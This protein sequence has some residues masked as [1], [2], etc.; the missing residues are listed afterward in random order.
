MQF[1]LAGASADCLQPVILFICPPETQK[2]VRK[3]VRKQNW[4][5]EAECGYKNMI[6]DGTF[7]RVLLDGQG[8]LDGGLFIRADMDDV[9]TLCGKMGRLEG[10][11]N[12]PGNGSRFTIGGV[13]IVNDILCC[14]TT[15]HVLVNGPDTSETASSDDEDEID[16]EERQEY[17]VGDALPP[18]LPSKSS[19]Q[20]D[21]KGDEAGSAHSN[22]SQET[23]IGRLLT[24]SNWKRGTLTSNEDWSL[25]RLDAVSSSDKWL[26]NRFDHPGPEGQDT[27]TVTINELVRTDDEITEAEVIILAGCTGLQKG[28]L[29]TTA[30][31]LYLDNATFEAREIVTHEPLSKFPTT[32]SIYWNG[33]R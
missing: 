4:L 23:R 17:P 11:L 10:A 26:L 6:V 5:A 28:R 14:L 33:F 25:I 9:Q 12:S 8:G 20:Q 27:L 13:I 22:A 16:E 15:G 30:V 29:N 1:K 21:Q 2:Q 18:N 24:T 3:F 7:L 31:Q 19:D 32:T